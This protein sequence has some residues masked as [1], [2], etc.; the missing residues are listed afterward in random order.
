MSGGTTVLMVSHVLAQIRSMCTHVIWLDHGK[1]IMDGDTKTVCDAYEGLIDFDNAPK[2]E[3]GRTMDDIQRVTMYPDNWLPPEGTYKIKTGPLGLVSGSLL[4][5]FSDLQGTEKVKISLDCTPQAEPV[6]IA[7]TEEHTS[8]EVQGT[9]D[10]IVTVSIDSNF[11]RSP[12]PD[13]RELSV[14]L[15][16]TDGN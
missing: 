13:T 2:F 9:P 14:V 15:E 11:F 6:E 10:T 5:P 16:A 12:A 8:F 3:I 7:I 1:V 4:C